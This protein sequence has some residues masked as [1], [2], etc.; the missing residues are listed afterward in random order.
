MN[1]NARSIACLEGIHPALVTVIKL[2]AAKSPV[3]FILTEGRR[4]QLRQSQLF[5]K[6]ATRT[7]N[8]RHLTGHAVDVAPLLD[9]EVRFD[10]PLFFPIAEA[11]RDA[12]LELKIRVTWGG[13]WE[14]L[15]DHK[16]PLT[17]RNLSVTFPDG[18]HF[19]LNPHEYP[20]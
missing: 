10:W 14:C 7:M 9:G 20:W 19:E 5:A 16:G 4:S 17:A 3:E 11:I 18:P 2:A 8:S 12:A 1:L 15:N 6:G 13:T